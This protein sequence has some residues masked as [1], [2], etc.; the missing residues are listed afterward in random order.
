MGA[1]VA[2]T[3]HSPYRSAGD[4]GLEELDYFKRTFLSLEH[5]VSEF[6]VE[7]EEL[8]RNAAELNGVYHGEALYLSRSKL[9][10][11]FQPVQA[12]PEAGHETPATEIDLKLVP[13][14]LRV[15]SVL[16]EEPVQLSA[17]AQPEVITARAPGGEIVASEPIT[18]EVPGRPL[19][20]TMARPATTP[21]VAGRQPEAARKGHAIERAPGQL[22]L[23]DFS[24]ALEIPM[25]RLM[26][27]WQGCVGNAIVTLSTKTPRFGHFIR[28]LLTEFPEVLPTVIAHFYLDRQ[29]FPEQNNLELCLREFVPKL[30]ISESA[31]A[32]LDA[33]RNRVRECVG[34]P[35]V[36]TVQLRLAATELKL[37]MLKRSRQD[38]RTDQ[39]RRDLL[40]ERALLGDLG[41]SFSI[42]PLKHR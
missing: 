19:E 21:T 14:P 31:D 1:S 33:F 28:R 34:I 26:P 8:R 22:K 38:P 25:Q 18:V 5:A 39:V 13:L 35:P 12:L 2:A 40:L 24:E 42:P 32:V 3:G 37:E 10:L 29:D 20:K 6:E 17:H 7:E 30:A 41:Q 11:R 9:A 36:I 15:P 4:S 23:G 27:H 16:P